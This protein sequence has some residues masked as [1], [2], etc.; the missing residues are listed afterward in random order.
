M[1]WSSIKKIFCQL[2]QKELSTYLGPSEAA[3]NAMYYALSSA[4]YSVS[5]SW[6]TLKD[7]IEVK[8]SEL[9]IPFNKSLL[10]DKDP[11][12]EVESDSTL[13]DNEE[14]EQTPLSLH[15]LDVRPT[16]SGISG[17]RI[18]KAIPKIGFRA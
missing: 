7:A 1:S 13:G 3:F 5:G 17:R 6:N 10:E 16:H 14:V 8:A 15:N 11:D 9:S 12:V 4:N 18:E 2:F